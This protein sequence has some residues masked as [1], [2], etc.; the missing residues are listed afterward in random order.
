MGEV[1]NANVVFILDETTRKMSHLKVFTD[2]GEAMAYF[3]H[4]HDN[5]VKHPQIV[6][7][8]YAVPGDEGAPWG[9][10][11][12]DDTWEGRDDVGVLRVSP[13]KALRF[14]T[15]KAAQASARGFPGSVGGTAKLLPLATARFVAKLAAAMVVIEAAER[16][17]NAPIQEEAEELAVFLDRLRDFKR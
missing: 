15:E 16:W 11:F 3:N 5:V 14:K 9:V 6:K 7:A 2:I 10:Q 8:S 4:L 13:D 12:D 17:D 1:Q